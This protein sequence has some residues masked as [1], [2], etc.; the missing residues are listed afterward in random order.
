[1][2]N[3]GLSIVNLILTLLLIVAVAIIMLDKPSEEPEGEEPNSALV[4]DAKPGESIDQVSTTASGNIGDLKV[5]YVNTDSLWEQYEFVNNTLKGLEREQKRLQSAY[6]SKMKK[7]EKDYTDYMQKGKANL[8]TLKQQ[9][10]YETSL[11]KQQTDIKMLEDEVTNKLII[12]KQ[13]LNQQINDTILAFLIRYREQKGYDLILQHSYLNGV[14]TATPDI[15][16][17][18]EVVSKLNQEYQAF[19]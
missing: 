15:D 7:F 5:V 18:D 4:D 3:K 11:E 16:V 12:K 9:K 17:T 1:M 14:L 13:E 8:L 2:N 19:K 10:D 6:E